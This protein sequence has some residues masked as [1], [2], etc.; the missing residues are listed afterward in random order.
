M[1]NP[2]VGQI[3]PYSFNFAPKD[4][5]VCNGQTLAINQ[6]QALFSLL[7]VVYGG[8]GT[9]AF[10]LPNLQGRVPIGMGNAASGTTYVLG[11]KDGTQEVTLNTQ[12]LP[13]HVHAFNTDTAS[14]SSRAPSRG[15]FG[16]AASPLYTQVNNAQRVTLNAASIQPAGNSQPHSNMQPYTVLNFCI[17][18]SGIYPPRA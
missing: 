12:Q 17:A 2:Y 5:A 4:F 13:S 14:A 8:N 15:S 9:T 7:G 11:Q 18:L 10:M 16:T 3:V 6:F 1:L